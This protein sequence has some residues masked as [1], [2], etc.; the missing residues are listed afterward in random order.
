MPMITDKFRFLFK[1]FFHLWLLIL[2]GW[3]YRK[4]KEMTYV[5]NFGWNKNSTKNAKMIT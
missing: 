4:E 3:F 1:W 5:E 2:R